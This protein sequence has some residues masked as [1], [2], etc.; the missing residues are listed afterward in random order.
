MNVTMKKLKPPVYASRRIIVKT[1]NEKGI[2][3]LKKRILLNLDDLY[4]MILWN[5]ENGTVYFVYQVKFSFIKQI[6][7]LKIMVMNLL[8]QN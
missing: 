1:V 8:F 6:L 3:E 5:E 7:K 2:E 4:K